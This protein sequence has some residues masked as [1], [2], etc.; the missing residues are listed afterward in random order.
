MPGEHKLSAL[1]R[2]TDIHPEVVEVDAWNGLAAMAMIKSVLERSVILPIQERSSAEKHG[3]T[4]PVATLLFGPPGTGKTVLARAMAGR[5]GWAFVNADL[6]SVVL[7]ASCLHRLFERLFQLEQTV[8]FLDE[9]EQLGRKRVDQTMLVDGVT[10]ELLRQMSAVQATGEMLIVCATNHVRVL[11]P[12]LLRP[13]RFD[14]VLPVGLPDVRDRGRLLGCLLG[15]HHCG[16]IQLDAV[17]QRTEGF[18]AAD[19]EGICRRAAQTAFEREV[20]TGR[21]CPIETADLFAALERSRPTLS[22][23]ELETFLLDADQFA[24][25]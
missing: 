21:D 15:R 10:A 25:Y 14:L 4:P 9:F 1:V 2:G 23:E 12:A 16:P 3:L 5:L 6:S 24:R 22:S 19:L 13:G 20:E 17:V 11:D 18:T 8:I 7:D